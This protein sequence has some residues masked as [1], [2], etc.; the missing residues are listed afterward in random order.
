MNSRQLSCRAV[1][2]D[3]DG[4]LADTA[5][6]M[7]AALN[8][9][10]DEK[11]AANIPYEAARPHVS[12]GSRALVKLGF[13]DSGDTE[14]E[15]H[16]AR[17]LDIY[18]EQVCAETKLYEGMSEVLDWIEASGSLWGIV[19]NKP[20]RFTT[21]LIAALD[22]AERAACV[23]SGDTVSKSKPHAMPLLHA[24]KVMATP[25]SECVYVGDAERDIIAG[26]AAGMRTLTALYGYI[27]EHEDPQA[28]LADGMIEHPADLF[29]WLTPDSDTGNHDSELAL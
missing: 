10:C 28:W 12:H 16:I 7:V 25:G 23:V 29:S 9:L 22:L 11:G 18:A 3:L 4:T 15:E 19:T 20:E 17:F 6:D 26:R 14:T 5:P 8:R 21:P 2:F 13:P 24:S 1:L 27:P